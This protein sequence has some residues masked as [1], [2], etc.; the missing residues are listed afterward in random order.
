MKYLKSGQPVPGK[1]TAWTLYEIEE[2]DLIQRIV[3]HIPESGE[4]KLYP[5]PKIKNLFQ[6][7][8]LEECSK[9]EFDYIWETGDKP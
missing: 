8:R 5:K 9:A 4:V 7:E 1:G 3:T 2:P 6:P